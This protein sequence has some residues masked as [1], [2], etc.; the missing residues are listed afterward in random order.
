[1]HL[2]V[3]RFNLINF[4][5]FHLSSPLC[6]TIMSCIFVLNTHFLHLCCFF[7]WVSI[8]WCFLRNIQLPLNASASTCTRVCRHVLYAHVVLMKVCI[9]IRMCETA[10]TVRSSSLWRRKIT[11]AVHLHCIRYFG[12]IFWQCEKSFSFHLHVH[13]IAQVRQNCC[14]R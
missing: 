8:K 6:C 4:P 3:L 5:I 7:P 12:T 13:L 11:A 14:K 9:C 1:M 2:I 10:S